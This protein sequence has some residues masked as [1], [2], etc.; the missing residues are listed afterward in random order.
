MESPNVTALAPEPP[1]FWQRGQGSNVW[2]V[3][4]NRF[5][6]LD[7][8]FGVAS[9]GHSHPRVVSAITDQAQ[10]LLHGM[11]DVHPTRVRTELLEALA[12]RFPAASPH[13]P[14]CCLRVRMRSKPRSRPL[15]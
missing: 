7:A 5:V 13:E 3:D 8:A 1:I 12:R 2:D 4:G 14:S 6:D 10:Q 9:T 11:G 15:F